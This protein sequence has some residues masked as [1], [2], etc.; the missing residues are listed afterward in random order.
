MSTVKAMRFPASA[1][2]RGGRLTRVSARDK[3]DLDVVTPPDFRGG[4][5]GKWSP[6]ELLVGAAASCYALTLAALAEW[7]GVT[8]D[9]VEVDGL[10]HVERR[11]D[12]R[13]G[14]V[15]IE[16]TVVI[17]TEDEA[18]LLAERLV[19]EAERRCIVSLALDVPVHVRVVL[20]SS[21]GVAVAN[22][23]R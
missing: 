8:L 11:S 18:L 22:R 19:E 2:W 20:P 17:A 16:L 7:N 15:V 4:I 13:F 14:F 21:A 12:G 3:P 1:H 5:A 9:D 6:E 10:G 23:G